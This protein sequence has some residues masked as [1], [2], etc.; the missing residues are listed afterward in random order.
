MD[1]KVEKD[2]TK[3]ELIITGSVN[4]IQDSMS[5]KST[6]SSVIGTNK[7]VAITVKILDSYTLPSSII[8]TFLKYREIDKL[9]L[10]VIVK[11]D[12]LYNS[13]DR[14]NLVSILNVKKF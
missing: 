9:D 5:I 3:L 7:G 8:G 10:T 4:S 6:L 11:Q 2:S 14:L 1:I 13:L 12:E